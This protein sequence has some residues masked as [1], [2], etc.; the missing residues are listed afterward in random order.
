[1]LAVPYRSVYGKKKGKFIATRRLLPKIHAE[2]EIMPLR[3]DAIALRTGGA[4]GGHLDDQCAQAAL[5]KVKD[6]LK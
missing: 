6:Q 4:P 5:E 1:L 2:F 3:Y